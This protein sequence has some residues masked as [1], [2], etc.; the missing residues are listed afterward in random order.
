[1]VCHLDLTCVSAFDSMM[2][3]ECARIIYNV[4]NIFAQ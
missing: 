2:A 1:V 3:N 4:L